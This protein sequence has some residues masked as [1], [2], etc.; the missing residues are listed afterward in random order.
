MY[1][2]ISVISVLFLLLSGCALMSTSAPAVQGHW[3]LVE[4][5]GEPVMDKAQGD[6]KQANFSLNLGENNVASGRLA[7]NSW[8]A[9]YHLEGNTLR[10][11][12]AMSTRAYC[13]LPNDELRAIERAFPAVLNHGEIAAATGNELLLVTRNGQ[14]W[15]FAK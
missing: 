8:R 2:R 5:D 6:K 7:C 11:S 1:R 13:L 15:V 3:I 4:V 14:R 10:L 9:T 12:Q